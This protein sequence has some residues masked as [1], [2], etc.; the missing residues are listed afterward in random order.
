MLMKR[1]SVIWNHAKHSI[2]DPAAD[3][4]WEEIQEDMKIL[5]KEEL[6]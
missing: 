1:T 3:I 5:P 6:W 4:L 2:L